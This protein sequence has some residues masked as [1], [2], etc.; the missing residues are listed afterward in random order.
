MVLSLTIP[1]APTPE[2]NAVYYNVQKDDDD[3][4]DEG[5][6]EVMNTFCLMRG[7]ECRVSQHPISQ[8]G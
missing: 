8:W 7:S 1:S 5:E 3:D 6:L 4:D 2:F